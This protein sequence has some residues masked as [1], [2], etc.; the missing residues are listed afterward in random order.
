[1]HS[2]FPWQVVVLAINAREY[3]VPDGTEVSCYSEVDV[4]NTM[5]VRAVRG[6]VQHYHSLEKNKK[7][8]WLQTCT[9]GIFLLNIII[10]KHCTEY[11]GSRVHVLADRPPTLSD[12]WFSLVPTSKNHNSNSKL[13]YDQFLLDFLYVNNL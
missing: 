6:M 5:A 12:L 8:T 11:F 1:M 13:S 3:E 4:R 7:I 10:I 9:Y 2:E